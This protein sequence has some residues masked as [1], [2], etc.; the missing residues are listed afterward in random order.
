MAEQQQR[1]LIVK[2]SSIGDIIHTLPLLSALRK[3]LPAAYLAWVVEAKAQNL[4]ETNPDLNELIVVDTKR[5]RRQLVHP[6]H[7]LGAIFEIIRQVILIKKRK[8]SVALDV[9]GLLKSG[10]ITSLSKAEKRLGYVKEC[11]REPLNRFFTNVHITPPA[12]HIIEQQLSFLQPLGVAANNWQFTINTLPE[13]EEYINDFLQENKLL[14]DDVPE[15]VAIHPGGGWL[16]K[17]WYP[18]RYAKLADRLALDAGAR[19]ILCWGPGEETLVETITAN[20]RIKPLVACKTTMR[21]LAALLKKCNL[22]I[23]GDSA[24]L[25]LAAALELPTVALYGPSDP[26]RNG[27]YSKKHIIVHHQIACSGCYKRKCAKAECMDAITVEEVFGAARK[28]LS[29]YY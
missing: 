18:Y 17:C 13:D 25:H 28:Q 22:F 20:A 23:G 29:T 5:W 15:L 4:L 7:F 1:I 12:N 8:F 14:R 2:L 11:C 24:P 27:P 26:K 3:E 10:V 9:Q 21:Q 16:T 19:V 6:L